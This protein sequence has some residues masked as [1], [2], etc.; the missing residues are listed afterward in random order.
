MLGMS[1]PIVLFGAL[2]AAGQAERLGLEAGALGLPFGALIIFSGLLLA[3]AGST[4]L[5][6]HRAA[7]PAAKA[8]RKAAPLKVTRPVLR[9]PRSHRV[10]ITRPIVKGPTLLIALKD[11]PVAQRARRR[12]AA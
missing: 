5:W 1:M 3:A 8:T 4:L 7:A 2:L 12:A 11:R 6:S 9:I 10:M